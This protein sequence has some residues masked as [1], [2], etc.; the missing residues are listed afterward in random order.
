MD[1]IISLAHFCEKHGPT[2]ILCTQ[3][4]PVACPTCHPCAGG[5]PSTDDLPRSSAGTGSSGF[6][7]AYEPPPPPSDTP[8]PS[9]TTTPTAANAQHG[10]RD[11]EKHKGSHNLHQHHQTRFATGGGPT[12]LTASPAALETPPTSPRTPSTS[13][14]NP[15][16]PSVSLGTAASPP[17]LPPPLPRQHA[18]TISTTAGMMGPGGA[19]QYQAAIG[20]GAGGGTRF[21]DAFFGAG[22]GAADEACENCAFVVPRD[23]SARL[24]DGAPGSPTKDGRG[25]NGCPVLRTTQNVLVVGGGG[26]GDGGRAARREKV[27]GREGRRSRGHVGVRGG[28]GGG[29]GG[30]GCT[31]QGPVAVSDSEGDSCGSVNGGVP[32]DAAKVVA[33]AGGNASSGAA[34]T[35]PHLSSSSSPPSV[36]SPSPSTSPSPSSSPHSPSSSSPCSA[37]PSSPSSDG[38]TFSHAHAHAHT[39]RSHHSPHQRHH[40]H[41]HHADQDPQPHS[42]RLTYLTTRQPSS[43]TAYS[44]LRRSCI[45]TLSC[46]SLP[47]GSSSGPLYFGDPVAGYTIAYIFRL[48][49]PM[50]R[51]ARRT[52]ALLALGGRESCR[53]SAAMVMVTEVFERMA[54]D[55]VARAE[56]VLERREREGWA[57]GGLGGLGLSSS[58]G[59]YGGGGLPL[60]TGSVS[61]AVGAGGGPASSPGSPLA[62][63][64]GAAASPVRERAREQQAKEKKDKEKEKQQA[65]GAATPGPGPGPAPAQASPKHAPAAP[66]QAAPTSPTSPTSP[67]KTSS[68]ATTTIS[69]P[70]AAPPAAS[71][72]SRPPPPG[73]LQSHSHPPSP[74]ARTH[75]GGGPAGAGPGAGAGAGP[76]PHSAA[77]ITPVSSFLSAKKVDPDGYPRGPEAAGRPRGKGLAEIVGQEGFFVEVHARFCVLLGRLVGGGV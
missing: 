21:S 29:R 74:M 60:R 31:S 7:F 18:A 17:P 32:V 51:G 63:R 3:I 56:R 6:P 61:G 28:G 34:T 73:R 75:A 62:P 65:D 54:A 66:A 50:A 68:S 25:R 55:V 53:V 8:K 13:S 22:A 52:Y 1:F 37:S 15:Y 44:L 72:A 26:D 2:S 20:P 16:F 12:S 11:A 64:P 43:P 14:H 19:P 49:D 48:P 35:V 41:S 10:D 58:F 59:G 30:D 33:A 5:T 69:A 57:A 4:V 70:T 38:G 67:T 36:R 42:H 46:E 23:V 45:R 76:G 47:R 39:Q 71:A 77:G 27:A 24:P 9:T 40:H